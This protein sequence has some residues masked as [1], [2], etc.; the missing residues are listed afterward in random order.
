MSAAAEGDAPQTQDPAVAVNAHEI[1]MR[2][3]ASRLMKLADF[4]GDE[5]EWTGRHCIVTMKDLSIRIA[6]FGEHRI[7]VLGTD[8]GIIHFRATVG[9]CADQDTIFMHNIKFIKKTYL[10]SKI[11]G[12]R[13][14]GGKRA[15]E[16]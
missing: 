7:E 11:K 8:T 1:F 3:E 10:R 6:S 16:A 14:S 12:A 5:G 2:T 15:R 4:N 13:A 9:R